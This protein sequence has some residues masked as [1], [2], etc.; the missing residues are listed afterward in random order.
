MGN[1]CG[2]YNKPRIKDPRA[3]MLPGPQLFTARASSHKSYEA[4]PTRDCS[5]CE[6]PATA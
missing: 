5:L 2:P 1:Y 6:D 4:S 3:A